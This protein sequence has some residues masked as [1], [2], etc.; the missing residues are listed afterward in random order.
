MNP[1][2]K[3]LIER[4]IDNTDQEKLHWEETAFPGKFIAHMSKVDIVV[5]YEFNRTYN[6][7]EY[8]FAIETKDGS[9]IDRIKAS[10]KDST[11]FVGDDFIL[12]SN[13]YEK[14]RRKALNIDKTIDDILGE[15]N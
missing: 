6:K 11:V 3:E 9:L 2:N 5:S 7:H 1:K 8:A 15:L 12:L 13:I 14:A 10:E 4:L